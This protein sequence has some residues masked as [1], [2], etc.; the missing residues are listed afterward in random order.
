MQENKSIAMLNPH[1]HLCFLPCE[2]EA[3]FL[4][5]LVHHRPIGFKNLAAKLLHEQ[6]HQLLHGEMVARCYIEGELL[7]Y[8][9]TTG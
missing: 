3:S 5:M 6:Q 9:I 1:A 8:N 4:Q 7:F 2:L